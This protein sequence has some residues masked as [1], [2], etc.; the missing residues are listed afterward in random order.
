MMNY[1][2]KSKN[3]RTIVL[4]SNLSENGISL[5]KFHRTKYL[6][7]LYI[8]YHPWRCNERKGHKRNDNK[9]DFSLHKFQLVGWKFLQHS[10]RKR[11]RNFYTEVGKKENFLRDLLI[12]LKHKNNCAVKHKK[13]IRTKSACE[14]K[15]TKKYFEI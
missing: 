6:M 2:S 12:K 3:H 9:I 1:I 7:V 10:Q 11:A 13:S 4:F 15:T 8:K 14:K 5:T